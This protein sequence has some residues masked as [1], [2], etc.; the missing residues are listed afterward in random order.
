MESASAVRAVAF[1]RSPELSD[2]LTRIARARSMLAGEG[3]NVYLNNKNIAL[4]LGSVRM[5]GDR[6]ML[7]NVLS[8]EPDVGQIDNRL[9]VQGSPALSSSEK[10]R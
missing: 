10:S 3:I 9:V 8:L 5:P 7:A 6:V 1:I 2:R 4:L